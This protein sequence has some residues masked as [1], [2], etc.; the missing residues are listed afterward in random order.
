MHALHHAGAAACSSIVHPLDHAA[1]GEEHNLK[2]F[3]APET[4]KQDVFSKN[5][6]EMALVCF[7]SMKED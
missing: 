5:S 7:K 1:A 6:F 2:I 4:S 3:M